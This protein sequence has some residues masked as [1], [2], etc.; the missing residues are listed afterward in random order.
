MARASKR[1]K[2]VPLIVEPHPDDYNGYPFITLIQYR[3]KHL[4]SVVD[5]ATTK[6]IKAFV[7]DLCAPEG[8]NEE[9][10]VGL[11]A[12][13]YDTGGF[14]RYPLSIEFSKLGI[15][16]EMAKIFRTFN[17]E[18]VTRVIGPLPSFEMLETKSI[19]RRKKREI[20]P[21]VVVHNFVN[22]D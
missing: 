3:D 10:V 16:N 1:T 15:A 11:I 6:V 4:L 7:L 13:W 2:Q 14:E 21:G 20:P 22:F 5:N 9:I 8:I 12:N 17:T 19:R 18:F